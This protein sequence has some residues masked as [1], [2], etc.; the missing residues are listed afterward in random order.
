MKVDEEGRGLRTIPLVNYFRKR[1]KKETDPQ[2]PAL[3]KPFP[4]RGIT[5]AA[6]EGNIFLPGKDIEKGKKEGERQKRKP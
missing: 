5:G 3:G 4:R 6:P 2:F 1:E